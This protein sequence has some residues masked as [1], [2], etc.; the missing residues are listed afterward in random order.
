MNNRQAAKVTDD[1]IPIK[2]ASGQAPADSLY[3]K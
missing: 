2:I 3:C 1:Q